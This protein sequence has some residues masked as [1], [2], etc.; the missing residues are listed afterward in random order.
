MNKICKFTEYARR[1]E[2][3]TERPRP[4]RWKSEP[5]KKGEKSGIESEKVTYTP[6]L[7][8]LFTC[9][10]SHVTAI[11]YRYDCTIF[12]SRLGN[13]KILDELSC[14]RAHIYFKY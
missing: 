6:R 7:T 14:E 12:H 13:C 10:I 11:I 8:V 4:T 1:V 3:S 2:F 5:R 9:S